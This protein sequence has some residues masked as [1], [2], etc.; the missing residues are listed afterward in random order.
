MSTMY[1]G[2][3]QP[4]PGDFLARLAQE[5]RHLNGRRISWDGAVIED[6]SSGRSG[7]YFLVQSSYYDGNTGQWSLGTPL[8]LGYEQPRGVKIYRH[9]GRTWDMPAK[10]STVVPYGVWIVCGL[11]SIF[12]LGIS[13]PLMADSWIDTGVPSPIT[14]ALLLV[15]F[16]PIFQGL[17]SWFYRV[18]PVRGT[19]WALG[20]T[21]VFTAIA[22]AAAHSNPTSEQR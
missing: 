4:P 8:P 9:T 18:E 20:F 10:A 17:F 5:K 15:G 19:M 2:V 12:T 22:V 13:V 21:A 11:L 3:N 7:G 16:A 1:R 14:V 6:I